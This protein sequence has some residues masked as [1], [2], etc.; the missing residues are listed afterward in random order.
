M[1]KTIKTRASPLIILVENMCTRGSL[2]LFLVTRLWALC[3]WVR[4][5][6]L[7]HMCGDEPFRTFENTAQRRIRPMIPACLPHHQ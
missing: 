2:D 7:M 3:Q 1:T 5:V 4:N 6:L